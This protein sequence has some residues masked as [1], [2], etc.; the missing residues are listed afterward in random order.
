MQFAAVP[1]ARVARPPVARADTTAR[2]PTPAGRLRPVWEQRLGGGVLS[3]LLLHG[4]TLYVSAMDGGV[5]AFDPRDGRL[6]WRAMTG[7][8]CHSS[9]VVADDAL[10]VGSAD[11]GVYCF[12]TDDGALRWR[13]ATEGPVYASAAIARGTAAIASGDGSVYGIAV[14]DGEMRW[15]WRM[16]PGPSAFAQSPAATDG[17]RVYIGAWDRH[18]YALDAAT[19]REQW[20]YLATER[21]FYYSPAIGAPAL[22]DGRLYVPSNE[23]TLHCLDAAT[24]AGV[25]T[26]HSAGDRFGYSSPKLDGDRIY[27]G[28]IGDNGE[29]RCLT[30]R[31]AAKCGRPPPARRSTTRPPPSPAAC[32][33][34]A[35]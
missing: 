14:D 9:P 30:R 32:S 33:P 2:S 5:S 4:G 7:D 28:C 11:G 24:G 21:G 3:H 22:R 34:S 17:A 23:N 10:I 26:A 27:I 18:V 29:V 25:W 8:Y 6:R 1:L 12:G 19:G 13:V 35:P 15:R 20:R 16:P 31:T